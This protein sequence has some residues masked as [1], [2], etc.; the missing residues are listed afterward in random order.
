M[1]TV[2]FGAANWHARGEEAHAA[3]VALA[4]TV[5]AAQGTSIAAAG[6]D[7]LLVMTNPDVD[8]ASLREFASEF[9]ALSRHR[10]LPLRELLIEDN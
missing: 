8:A 6:T 2:L 3:L 9:A 5:A 10:V 4:L 7:V 1:P